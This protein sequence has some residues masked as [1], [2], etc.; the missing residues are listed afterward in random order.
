MNEASATPRVVLFGCSG[1]GKTSLFRRMQDHPSPAALSPTV[2]GESVRLAIDAPDGSTR[3]IFLWDTAGHERFR[4]LI[5]LY[6]RSAAY[7]L[8]V[9]DL[10]SLQSFESL[11]EWRDQI[12]VGTKIVLIGNKADA[13]ADRVVSA[14]MA[15]ARA[16]EINVVSYFEAS[17]ITG[18]GTSEIRCWIASDLGPQAFVEEAPQR[19]PARGGCC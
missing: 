8:L 18:E 4:S 12:E 2:S 17:A 7:G 6:F 9:F 13:L 10:T 14:A 1:V 19:G 16:A 5:P 11:A 15:Q 3:I